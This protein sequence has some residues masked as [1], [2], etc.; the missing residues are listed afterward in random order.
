MPSSGFGIYT[1]QN[2]GNAKF[3]KKG[4]TVNAIA[5]VSEAVFVEVSADSY[6]S[7]EEVKE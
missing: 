4:E 6:E 1:E 7:I 2:Q 5:D 3:M